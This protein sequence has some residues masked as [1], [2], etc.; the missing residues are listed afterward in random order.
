MARE[1]A[2]AALE[3]ERNC[4]RVKMWLIITFKV[5]DEC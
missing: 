2:I 1:Q 4:L 3:A 5:I